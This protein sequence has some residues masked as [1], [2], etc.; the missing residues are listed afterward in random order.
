M[1]YNKHRTASSFN[2][3]RYSDRAGISVWIAFLSL[4][5]TSNTTVF[6][7]SRS[8]SASSLA[9]GFTLAGALCISYNIFQCSYLGCFPYPKSL[10]LPSLMHNGGTSS[11]VH[12]GG[13]GT[14]TH[15]AWRRH[16]Y[17]YQNHGDAPCCAVL[18]LPVAT[19]CQ[20][21]RFSCTQCALACSM[22]SARPFHEVVAHLYTAVLGDQQSGFRKYRGTVDHLTQLE[23][24][25]S[26]DLPPKKNSW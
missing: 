13:R 14:P 9:L 10:Q 23:H 12:T 26:R 4:V 17:F 8:Q 25:I 21:P 15:R 1:A 20:N 16:C 24:C 6:A 22:L 18:L 7:A 3:V 5:T 2:G 11:L 19:T